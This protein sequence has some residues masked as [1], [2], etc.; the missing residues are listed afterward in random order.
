MNKSKKIN[1]GKIILPSIVIFFTAILLLS[2]PV[3][4]NYNS[5]QNII[6]KK[7]SSEFK[8]HLEI[9]DDISLK[10]F[11]KPHYIVKNANLDLNTKNKDSIVIQV[12]DLKIFFPIGKLYSKSNIEINAIEIEKANF[13][14]KF[15]DVLEFRSH[16]YYKINKPIYIKKSKFFFL[17]R[18]NKTILISP[19][20][21]IKYFINKKN[22]SKELIIDGNIFDANFISLWKRYYNDPNTSLNEINFKNPNLFIKNIFSYEDESNFSGNSS[23]SFLKEDILINYFFKDNKIFINS[24][25]QNKKQKIKFK[26]KV[27]LRPFF[28]DATIDISKKNVNFLIDILLYNIL[29]SHEYLGNINGRLVLELNDLKNSIIQSGTINLSI[30]EKNIKLEKAIFEIEDVGSLKTDFRYYENEGSLMFASENIFEIINKKEFSRKFQLNFK[31]IKKIDK[32]YFDLE[33]NID[34]N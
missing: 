17:D 11:P 14:F 9:L 12:K 23:I 20:K 29:N 25:D 16:L 2:L 8:I 10:I 27:E 5:I 1:F 30:K 34:I 21:K 19:I 13:Y 28:I 15:D 18:N 6:E 7:V 31:K 3:L 4:S 22:N 32:I 24:P 26:S 33:K